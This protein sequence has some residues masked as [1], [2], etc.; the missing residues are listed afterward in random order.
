MR[1][2]LFLLTLI[3]G[4]FCVNA[5]SSANYAFATNNNGS[6]ALDVNSNAIDMSSG[7]TQLVAASQDETASAVTN[8]GFDFFLMGN[9]YA[10][11][12]VSSN[13]IIQLGSTAVS[14]SLYV[15]SS[16]TTA[17]P[18]I[19]ALGGD[20]QTGSLG[21]IH[22][23]TVG[24]APNRTLVIEFLNMNL[25]YVSTVYGN[26]ATFQVR[27]YETSGIVEFV[28][29][30]VSVSSV[31]GSGVGD[32]SP[33]IGFSTNTTASN[34]AYILTATHAATTTGTFADNPTSVVGAHP[35]LNS[36]SNGNRRYYR[37]TPV[38]PNPPTG[39]NF[40]AVTA[41]SITPNWTDAS[42]EVKYA[43]YRS[44]DGGTNYNFVSLY[45][46][47]AVTAGAQTGLL[48]GTNFFWKL[49]SITEGGVSSAV[50]ASQATVAGANITSNGT[51][52][53][54]WSSAST[55]TGGVVPISA[56]NVTIKNGDAVIIDQNAAVNSL[57]VGEGT[58]GSL[59]FDGTIRT[60]TSN[61]SV[62]VATGGSF[63]AGSN[64]ITHVINIG[65]TT[66]SGL[67]TGS[68]VVDGIFDGYVGASAGKATI[69]FFG[70]QDAVVSGNGTINFNNTVVVNK[71]AVA[72][73]PFA[74][75]PVL[76][77][78]RTFTVQGANTVG[79]IG[80]HT[81]GTVKFSG[82]Y[83]LSTPLYATAAYTIPLNGGIWLNNSNFTAVGQN[84]ASTVTGLLRVTSGTLN[85]G[86]VTNTSMG[87]SSG[88]TIIVEGGTINSVGRFG[89]AAAGNA[90]SYTQSGGTINV[91]T[92][93]HTSTTLASFDLGTSAASS[94]NVSGGTINLVQASTAAS[95]PRDFRGTTAVI[96][97]FTN[98]TLNIGTA[99]TAISSTF[100]IQGQIPANIVVDNTTNP[101][102]L[103]AVTTTTNTIY[104]TLTI[105]TGSTY[106]CNGLTTQLLKNV[107]CN[108]TVIGTV[109]S[110]RFDFVGST[111]QVFSGT[112]S[113]GTST[114]PFQGTGVGIS[115]LNNV[116]LNAPIYTTRVNL[117][118]GS[119]INSNQIT[120]GNGVLTTC[121]I[122]RGGGAAAAGSF[123]QAPT[124]NLIANQI[125]Y[126]YSTSTTA[127]TTGV[128]IPASRNIGN[129]TLNNINGIVLAGGNLNLVGGT[130]PTLTMTLGNLDL[131]GNT[132]TVGESVTKLGAITNTTGFVQNGTLTRWFGT[133][134]SPNTIANS[135]GG[136][137][138]IGYNNINRNVWFSFSSTTALTTGGT[139]SVTHA[140]AAGII[141]IAG[142]TD[143][144][145]TVDSRTNANWTVSQSGLVASGTIT[146]RMQGSG[147]LA[148]VTTV[149]N[150]RLIR[151]NDAV[152][153]S[154][155]G[156]GTAVDP[157]VNR[158]TMSV[159]DIAN[160]FYIGGPTADLSVLYTSIAS[161]AWEAGSTWDQGTAPTAA[162]SAVIANGHTITVNATASAATNL[163]INTGGT[164]T[165]S[166]SSLA[167][168]GVLTNNG[169]VNATGGSIGITATSAA[170]V[171]NA[172][173]TSVFNINGGTVNVGITDNS[174]CNR[175]FTNNGT[176][177]VSSGTL[178]MYGNIVNGANALF[179]QSGGNI[180]IDGNAGGN[181][182]N[183]V[184]NGTS[185]LQFNQ[186]N[187]GINL[188]GGTLTIVDPHASTTATDVI[189][190]NNATAGLQT[191]LP[192]H[193][194]RFGNGVSTDA[195]GN[196]VG[197]RIDPWTGTAY[198]SLGS[199]VI[200][201][202]TG[203]NRDVTNRYYLAANGNVTV[204]S[205][206]HL[207]LSIATF[208]VLFLGGDMVVNAGGTFTNSVGLQASKIT[209][210][211]GSNLSSGAVSVAQTISGAGTFQN[212]LTGATANFSGLQVINSSTNG[213]T[214]APGL[215]PTVSGTITVTD[216]K[217]N[218]D[219]LSLQGSTAQ[220]V[221]L[222][223]GT[224]FINVGNFTLNNG[225]GVT[226][227]GSGKLNVT[228]TVN[229]TAGTLAS[230]GTLTLK[231]SISGTARIASIGSGA[232]INGTVN[233]EQYI[234]GGRRAFRFLG[235]PFSVTT[236]NMAS[237][238]D[239]IYVTGAGAGFD[240]TVTNNPSAYW[241]D[242]TA[243]APGAWTAFTSTADNSW[244]Q[245]RGIRVLVR[246]D[247]TQTGTLTGSNVAPNAVTL[248]FTG[249]VNTGDKNISVPTAG[250]YHLVSNP[251][252]SPTDIGTVVD[253]TANIGTQYWV[254]DANAVTRG[255]YVTK[256]VGSGAYSLAMNGAFFV[257]PSAG[258]TLAFTEANK[259]AS[260]T[261]NLFR[262]N[263]S[264]RLLELE[265]QYNNYYADNIFVSI[266][267][268]AKVAVDARDGEKLINQ[269]VNLYTLSGDS[270]K[271]SLDARPMADG[272]TIPLGFTTTIPS[273]YK[274]KV[275]NNGLEAGTEVYLRDKLLNTMTLLA[276][277]AEY[278]FEVAAGNAATQGDNRFELVMKQAP[279]LVS[280]GAS[281]S[282]KLSPN[283]AKDMVKVSF[284]NEEKANTTITI[285]S[286]EGKTV[287]TVAAGNVQA[288]EVSINVKGLAR[289]SYYVTL[290][291]GRER[292][293]EKLQVQ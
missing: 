61:T 167:V 143:G 204:N 182:A 137:F 232:N 99:V 88:S 236:L 78:Q 105:N 114:V 224:S 52:G 229:V 68:L 200:N 28:Y 30:S 258:T 284:S 120:I 228:G 127:I 189:A 86:T 273:T 100:R 48:P 156:T 55:W 209:S 163:S 217:L 97:T 178:N 46:Q 155:N 34:F 165:V 279:V 36:A 73:T 60:L 49:Y 275:A 221:A 197:F 54:N 220:T 203:T 74:T 257:Q 77:I 247:R 3:V 195:G 218:A 67:G 194:T 263:S 227:N 175:T 40:T 75:P 44:D 117:F 153:T 118:G 166:G 283:P 64:N 231:S 11:F 161:G 291:N 51:G 106:D 133:T 129:F 226:I 58:S 70:L 215:T 183:S 102:T 6:L 248:D 243:T 230:A 159:S 12:S 24:A 134:A 90:I 113:I 131:G 191:S 56:D 7:T 185:L 196:A 130:T 42:N 149:A 103:Q 82:S 109:T 242:N 254:W 169:T 244:T 23:K 186:L 261:Q 145:V 39:L 65:G 71:G 249:T 76:D 289:G 136:H 216:G 81:A 144:G 192:A 281:F 239:N 271:L 187:S 93:G 126:S 211:T 22:M 256:T 108:G 265:V 181:A 238:I 278:S 63:T 177:A 84:A 168:G 85:L 213:V 245:Y 235:H 27:L 202:P 138:P 277:G 147:G 38:V 141:G 119:F 288:G 286:A 47:D 72:A 234:P 240:A 26:D 272:S 122:Q 287:K 255:A 152:G 33:S 201:G 225:T 188:T 69:S 160:T 270:K 148:A 37:F 94:V 125:G 87:F 25:Y 35:Q 233:L 150:L 50:I 293:T 154:S 241:F 251:Y 45:A 262:A 79:L 274:V 21:K 180:N 96:P 123:D 285:T 267:K 268:D 157:Q 98:G 111:A 32:T 162:N 282:V 10:Q 205:G 280:V 259:Q 17:S 57:T 190:H 19:S 2:L 8:I 140:N 250:A 4:S 184:A 142:F 237:L 115:N 210:N 151:A 20:L 252:P 101:K 135:N 14:G 199:M 53:G 174:F 16:G 206:G 9:R 104:G 158:T 1:K 146:M 83:T 18:R 95:G 107:I 172:A 222:T 121:F 212:A 89:V 208:G 253:A 171:L 132:L 92:I 266:D 276:A 31:T 164:L 290:D 91:N 207:N 170:G 62:T 41:S 214:F 66:A 43:L 193:T 219:A 15:A 59:T 269:D 116:T 110:S 292:K 5:Q 223:A 112:G 29:G 13:G 179:N 176:L 173:T 260:A 128:E 139:I 264:S 80:T 246:G 124:F 198:L